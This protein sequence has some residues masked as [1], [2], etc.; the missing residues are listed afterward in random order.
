[1]KLS[2]LLTDGLIVTTT[3][4]NRK[5]DLMVEVVAKLAAEVPGLRQDEVL[6]ALRERE[7]L[8]STAL[9]GG[10]AIPH[11]RMAGLDRPVGVLARSVAG[12]EWGAPDA[13]PSHLIVF[14]LT[15]AEQAGGHLKLLAAASRA[16]RDA[17]CRT[18]IESAAE[19]HEVV[20]VIRAFEDRSQGG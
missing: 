14:L 8:G 19:S 20:E 1:M 15:P 17:S 12:V 7:K 5:D 6:D 18:R 10:L 3:T 9:D 2:E 11:A 4:A 16:L 13:M